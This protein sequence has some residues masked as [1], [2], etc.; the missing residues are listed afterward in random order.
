MSKADVRKAAA[1]LMDPTITKAEVA[2]HFGVSRMTLNEA[3]KRE[4]YGLNPA[5]RVEAT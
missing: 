4:G 5:A 1:M 3:L 2:R